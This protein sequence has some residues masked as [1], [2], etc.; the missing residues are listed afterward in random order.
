MRYI[1]SPDIYRKEAGSRFYGTVIPKTPSE[2]QFPVTH[3][4]QVGDRWD[5]IAYKYLGNAAL[6]YQVA[7]IN[8]M[9]NGSIAIPPGTVIVIPE[10]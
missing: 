1:D 7:L 2:Q 9:A 8:N 4:T 10:V 6:W 5:T 3:T